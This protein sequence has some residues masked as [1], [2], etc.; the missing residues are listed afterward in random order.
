MEGNAN[1]KRLKRQLYT[2]T[3]YSVNSITILYSV[4]S[5]T[6]STTFNFVLFPTHQ[7]KFYWNVFNVCISPG[8]SNKLIFQVE[9]ILRCCLYMYL[10][11]YWLLRNEWTNHYR[12]DSLYSWSYLR[13]VFLVLV[14]ETPKPLQ[15]WAV[16]AHGC[17]IANVYKQWPKDCVPSDQPLAHWL[18]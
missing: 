3:L 9:N 1:V 2:F 5:I 18:S 6:T 11:V 17:L 14:Q 16:C 7:N 13:L 12:H 8:T 15:S 10:Y 4:N